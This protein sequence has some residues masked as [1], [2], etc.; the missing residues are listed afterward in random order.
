MGSSFAHV[1]RDLVDVAVKMCREA[2]IAKVSHRAEDADRHQAI[3]LLAR[4]TVAILGAR[5]VRVDPRLH[6]S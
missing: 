6:G 1:V 3:A 2:E 5:S 4:R